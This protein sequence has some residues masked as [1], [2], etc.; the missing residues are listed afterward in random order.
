M[1]NLNLIMNKLF[2]TIGL[3]YICLFTFVSTGIASA[4][5]WGDNWND[6]ADVWTPVYYQDFHPSVGDYFLVDIENALGYLLNESTQYYT[7]FPIMTG[8]KRTPTP[9]R[10]WVVLQK[11][12]QPNRVVFSKSGEFFRMFT[13][14]TT[15]TSYGIHGYGYFD[16]EIERGTKFLSLGCV[17]VADDVLDM[18]ENSYLANGES[19]RMDTKKSIDISSYFLAL[20]EVGIDYL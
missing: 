3:L 15:R 14:G 16:M 19:L 5:G 12:I 7:V 8:S 11:N 10:E 4:E 17:L 13:N 18:I 6:S 1:A 20:E 2:R 9:E